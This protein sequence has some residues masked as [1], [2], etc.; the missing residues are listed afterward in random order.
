MLSIV[1]CGELMYSRASVIGFWDVSK[2]VFERY[3]EIF[4]CEVCINDAL[5]ISITPSPTYSCTNSRS[6]AAC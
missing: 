1:G 4:E 3:E 6:L 5:F 2:A